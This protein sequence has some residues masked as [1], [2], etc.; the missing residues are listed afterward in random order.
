MPFDGRR[1]KWYLIV[2]K[3]KFQMLLAD[4]SK[5]YPRLLWA[6]QSASSCRIDKNTVRSLYT[7]NIFGKK[8]SKIELKIH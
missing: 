5:L 1:W 8:K 2:L 7:E 6:G 4:H 3:K